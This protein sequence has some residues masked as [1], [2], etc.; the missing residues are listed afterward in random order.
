MT[1]IGI[2]GGT[3]WLST[4]EYYSMIC[5][6]SESYHRRQGVTGVLPTPEMA[7]ES[8]D[9]RTA[10]SYLG[11]IGNAP[12]WS[13]FDA[14]HRDALLRLR[15]A[16]AK[17]AL[18]ASNTP[19]YRL[20]AITTGIDLPV[21]SIFDVVADEC[22]R[23]GVTSALI[24]GTRLTMASSALAEV[25]ERRGIEA[26]VLDQ[27]GQDEVVLTIDAIQHRAAPEATGARIRSVVKSALASR[28]ALDKAVCLC[29]TELPLSF[30][31]RGD[32]PAFIDGGILYVNSTAAHA[33]AVVHRSLAGESQTKQSF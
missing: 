30:P 1:K 21:V 5:R 19:H 27:R 13:R 29:C 11:E 2:V 23:L 7:I 3:A 6:L 28:S 17:I 16:G 8:L 12:S 15:N 33:A 9:L 25:I 14:Y 26:V 20:K 18:L 10:L 22:V 24:L 31:A 4:A 32:E